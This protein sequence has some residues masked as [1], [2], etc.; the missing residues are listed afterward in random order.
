MH[1]AAFEVNLDVRVTFGK[2]V[3]I[4]QTSP[5]NVQLNLLGGVIDIKLGIKGTD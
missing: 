4:E 5:R 1:D 2:E 3:Q